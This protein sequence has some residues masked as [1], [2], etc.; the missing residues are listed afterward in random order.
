MSKV[1]RVGV[2][3]AKN[4]IQV[5]AVDAAGKV[6]T[7]RALA[8]VRGFMHL[9]CRCFPQAC[10]DGDGS[11]LV[12]PTTGARKL[13]RTADLDARMI[14]AQSRAAPYRIQ[15]KTVARTTCQRCRRNLRGGFTSAP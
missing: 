12:V 6:V 11:L 3:L 15:G 4:V 9:V 7:S 8:S 2:D 13:R 5:H 1:T 14:P 10:L